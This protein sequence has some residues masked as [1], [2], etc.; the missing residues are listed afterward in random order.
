MFTIVLIAC[1]IS[2][3][4]VYEHVSHSGIYDF[5]DELA[6]TG[7]IEINSAVKPYTRAYIRG[8]LELADD[9]KGL[10]N[11]RQQEQ[12]IFYSRA[13]NTFDSNAKY[14]VNLHNGSF[15]CQQYPFTLE[16][17]PILGVSV[18]GDIAG[19]SGS[20]IQS[21]NR[22][23]GLETW[24]MLR[25]QWS[26]YASLRDN[27]SSSAMVRPGYISEE[28]GG[29][30]KEGSDGSVEFSEMR[31]G[32]NYMNR[33]MTIGLVKDH[34]EWGNN[35]HGANIF[36]DHTPSFVQ[37]K[38]RLRPAKW[39]EF[40]YFHAWLNS[41]V[42]DSAKTFSYT[43]AYGTRNRYV[44]RE[45]FLAANLITFKPWKSTHISFGNSIVYADIGLH[46]AYLIPFVFF[47][48]IDHT[49]NG[50]SNRAGQNAQMFMD[51]S[52]RVL[53]KTHLYATLFVDEIATTRMF[54]PDEQSNYLSFK[55]GFR[56]SNFPAENIHLTGEYTRTN[57]L[58]YQHFTPTTTFESNHYN[59]G[60]Y[61]RDNAEETW[62]SLRFEPVSRLRTEAS[63]SYARKGPDYNNLGGNRT[64]LPFISEERWR[65]SECTIS[66]EYQIFYN[67]IAKLSYRYSNISGADA[68]EYHPDY[69]A[70]LR[71]LIAAELR[72]GL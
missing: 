37:L 23:N 60:H 53:P 15:Y 21:L 29:V 36:T 57:P 67:A 17:R 51:I 71:H 47:K 31:A 6:N 70:G 33:W 72:I 5:L 44:Y 34:F 25:N 2:A 59:M 11:K 42:I 7:V 20:G 45:K 54:K 48:S 3:Q 26:F 14:G 10:L 49:L 66:A 35:Y 24:G 22:H 1:N 56:I 32:I 8:K 18:L 52:T 16:V 65:R 39:L 64:G 68:P 27:W 9:Q 58:T 41:E 69:L 55:T 62:V 50:T 40:N 13:F 63:F 61:L 12:L 4:P 38:L 30:Y 46:P 28:T 43:N 19:G